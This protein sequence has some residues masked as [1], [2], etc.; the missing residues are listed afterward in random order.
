MTIGQG[1]M[2][3]SKAALAKACRCTRET[4]IHAL[5]R[6][7]DSGLVKMEQAGKILRL[8]IVNY[9]TIRDCGTVGKSDTSTTVGRTDTSEATTVG[10]TDTSTVGESDTS[11]V[12]SSDTLLEGVKEERLKKKE[13]EEEKKEKNSRESPPP[14]PPFASRE[15]KEKE[16]EKEKENVLKKT[17]ELFS[18]FFPEEKVSPSSFSSE[19][20]LIKENKGLDMSTKEQF[21]ADFKATYEALGFPPVLDW[22]VYQDKLDELCG[23]RV[24]VLNVQDA[25]EIAHEIPFLQERDI[26]FFLSKENVCKILDGRYDQYK[27]PYTGKWRRGVGW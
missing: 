25:L 3:T 26:S 27:D 19:G 10:R 6:L 20:G 24:W 12:G 5:R 21:L 18:S 1:E 11:T 9:Q 14:P 15:E 4:I 16:K 23:M 2:A 7:A 13:E 17:K 8:T 22:S